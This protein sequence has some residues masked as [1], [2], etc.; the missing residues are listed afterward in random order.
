MKLV[1]RASIRECKPGDAFTECDAT[2]GEF[3]TIL[4]GDVPR[5][6]VTF[7]LVVKVNDARVERHHVAHLVDENLQRVLNVQRRAEGARNL[8]KRIN[9][10]MCLLDLVVSDKRTALASLIHI[11]FA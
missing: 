1:D 3:L 9:F 10:A 7:L 2:S 6:R 5:G 8:V 11:D 4:A